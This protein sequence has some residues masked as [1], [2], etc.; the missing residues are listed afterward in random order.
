MPNGS[1][2]DVGS[3]LREPWDAAPEYPHNDERERFY[4]PC[5][6]DGQFIPRDWT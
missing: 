4:L 1:S 3:V 2:I 6:R 5:Y